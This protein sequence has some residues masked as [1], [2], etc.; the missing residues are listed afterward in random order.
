MVNKKNYYSILNVKPDATG[1]EIR[2][3][4]RRLARMFHPDVI[5]PEGKKQFQDIQE[6]YAILGTK[7]K[8]K[9]YDDERNENR[10][11]S[12]KTTF[13]N[14]HMFEK[15]YKRRSD[16]PTWSGMETGHYNVTHSR[17]IRDVRGSKTYELNLAGNTRG[18][19]VLLKIPTVVERK[20]SWGAMHV[21]HKMETCRIWISESAQTGEILEITIPIEGMQSL[22]I[23]L[24]FVD[25]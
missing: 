9:Q 22:Y 21:E 17:Y 16:M 1:K 24:H 13:R 2:Q 10:Q 15:R 19:Y 4:Y 18:Q 6:A 11:K 23:K 14:L 7:D 8:K 3:A 5:G 25:E 20:L 12:H